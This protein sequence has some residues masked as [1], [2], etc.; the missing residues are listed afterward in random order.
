VTQDGSFQRVGSSGVRRT[1]ARIIAATNR[2]LEKE[3]AAG[4]FRE[5]LFFR[6]NVVEIYVPPLRERREDV[7]PLAN[8]FAAQFSRGRPRLSP[9]AVTC[10]ELYSWPG[11]VRELRNAM[12]RAI[13]MARGELILP[14]HLP[15]RVQAVGMQ[16]EDQTPENGGGQKMEEVERSVI[17]QTLRAHNF[18]RTETARALGVSR[19]TLLY[20]IQRFREQG[21]AVE[22]D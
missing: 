11:N 9:G 22:A 8:L 10:L 1:D 21:F 16:E 5:D 18:N 3:V 15:R 6:L 17:L 2:D 20:K 12:E 7:L 13:L 14:E 4:R 19:R